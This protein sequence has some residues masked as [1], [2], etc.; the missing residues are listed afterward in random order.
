MTVYRAN[1]GKVIEINRDVEFFD[2]KFAAVAFILRPLAHMRKNK[3]APHELRL[4]TKTEK[5][6]HR[7]ES[8]AHLRLEQ[9]H[10]Y[11]KCTYVSEAIV[12]AKE[13]KQASFGSRGFTRI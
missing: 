6:L 9:W 13:R 8:L 1:G 2:A 12:L 11:Y 5:Y 7:P 3:H 4:V 10:R